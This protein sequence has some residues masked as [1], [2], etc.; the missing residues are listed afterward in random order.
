MLVSVSYRPVL[1]DTAQPMSVKLLHEM[2]LGIHLMP[3]HDL[4]AAKLWGEPQK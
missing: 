4:I 3:P 1:G 2:A